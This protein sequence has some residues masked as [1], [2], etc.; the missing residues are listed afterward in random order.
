LVN[1]HCITIKNLIKLQEKIDNL[2]DHC[3]T[4][5]NDKGEIEKKTIL[6]FLGGDYSFIAG[7]YQIAGAAGIDFCLWCRSIKENR[8]TEALGK[9]IWGL[10]STAK[11]QK[12]ITEEVSVDPVFRF[13]LD[14]VAV[15][16]LHLILGITKDL[17]TV[18]Q[19]E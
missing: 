17:L 8:K 12:E 7:N 18:V 10:G 14:R 13:S 11:S 5:T 19:K 3:I 2:N 15:L 16:P 6:I 9:V 4:F 1:D